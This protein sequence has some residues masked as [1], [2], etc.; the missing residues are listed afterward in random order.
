VIWTAP[1]LDNTGQNNDF[2]KKY[3]EAALN[4]LYAYHPS[5]FVRIGA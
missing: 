3:N 4:F 5:R 2:A 1:C